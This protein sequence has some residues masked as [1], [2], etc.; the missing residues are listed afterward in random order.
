MLRRFLYNWRRVSSRERA[1]ERKQEYNSTSLEVRKSKLRLYGAPSFNARPKGP[2]YVAMRMLAL[3]MFCISFGWAQQSENESVN[4]SSDASS[5]QPCT[6]QAAAP[7]APP[8]TH[9]MQ[10]LTNMLAGRW[11]VG[12]AFEPRGGIQKVS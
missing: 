11:S 10:R 1:G 7:T 4:R 2:L 5:V 3:V 6:S 8:P 9:E 12:Q